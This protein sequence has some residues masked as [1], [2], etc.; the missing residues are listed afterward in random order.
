VSSLCV[1]SYADDSVTEL[2]A[3]R[4]YWFSIA[5][6]LQSKPS[7]LACKYIRDQE[8]SAEACDLKLARSSDPPS[9]DSDSG[10]LAKSLE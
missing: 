7:C 3:S 4:M 9:K 8:R 5:S 1:E 6:S 10:V 2:F